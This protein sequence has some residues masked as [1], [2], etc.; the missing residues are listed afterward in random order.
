M[1]LRHYRRR[2][3]ASGPGGENNGFTAVVWRAEPEAAVLWSL[4]CLRWRGLGSIANQVIFARFASILPFYLY[5]HKGAYF[6]GVTAKKPACQV[7]VSSV[8]VR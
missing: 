3:F 2:P 7:F 8:P 4:A 5:I 1:I 6:S